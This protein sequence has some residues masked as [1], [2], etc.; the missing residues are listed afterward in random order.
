MSLREIRSLV[1][2]AN[3]AKARDSRQQ[4]ALL[5]RINSLKDLM[6]RGEQH[7]L[8]A[9]LET[10]SV[11]TECLAQANELSP[12]RIARMVN[13]LLGQ[14]QESFD[15]HHELKLG[16][17]SEG[18]TEDGGD[19]QEQE[20][21]GGAELQMIHDKCLGEI[22]LQL[23]FATQ[24]DVDEG[25]R[26]QRATGVRIGEALVMLGKVTWEQVDNAVRLQDKLR[27]SVATAAGIKLDLA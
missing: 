20:G 21:S 22:L 11:L 23:G 9:Y 10:A 5:D 4:V 12:E 24:A 27:D 2:S 3:E 15:T 8:H 25:L 19:E 16:S 1:E 17:L 14:V 26:A 6:K 18:G 13:K 7:D